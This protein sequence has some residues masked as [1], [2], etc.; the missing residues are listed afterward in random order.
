MRDLILELIQKTIPL[1]PA[2]SDLRANCFNA[3]QLYWN[4]ANHPIF[5][6]PEAFVAYIESHFLQIDLHIHLE[7]GDVSIVWSRNSDVLPVGQ[8]QIVNLLN[9]PE[10]YP[11]GLVVEH[12][13]ICT[14]ENQV[15]H[16]IDLTPEGPYEIVPEN[17]ALKPYTGVRGFEITRHRRR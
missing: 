1:P 10:G 15:F 7:V 3:V 9:K 2:I 13:Y 11:F 14:N 5:L 16:K 4:D 17:L 12:S 6:G 8:I